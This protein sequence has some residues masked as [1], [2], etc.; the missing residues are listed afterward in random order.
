MRK[1]YQGEY[2]GNNGRR[3]LYFLNGR[4]RYS[5]EPTR[6]LRFRRRV[7]RMVAT[8]PELVRQVR[9]RIRNAP[10]TY[11]PNSIPGLDER[12]HRERMPRLL[13]NARFQA[14]LETPAGR[15]MESR[16]QLRRNKRRQVIQMKHRGQRSDTGSDVSSQMSS[17]ATAESREGSMVS[18]L[19]GTE[20]SIGGPMGSGTMR[21]T[22]SFYPA[23]RYYDRASL[24]PSDSVSQGR[25]S[26]TPG[27][28]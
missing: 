25:R 10:V 1:Y 11:Y 3:P 13:R 7:E 23:R 17:L 2:V 27:P 15:S 12:R 16:E 4:N 9:D 19:K 28:E 6:E 5:Q 8:Q 22:G 20:S 21:N 18:M 24:A 14:G 26:M